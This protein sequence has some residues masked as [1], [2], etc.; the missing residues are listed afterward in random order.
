MKFRID[1]FLI[2]VAVVGLAVISLLRSDAI[3][4]TIFFSFTL[5]FVLLSV[6]LAVGRT[7]G[8]RVFWTGFGISSI[9]YLVVAHL[10]DADD[11]VPRHNGPEITTQLLRRGFNW[12]HSSTYFKDNNLMPKPGGVFS[13]QDQPLDFRAQVDAIQE[14]IDPDNWPSEPFPAKLS[15]VFGGQ[16][17][18]VDPFAFCERF[19]RIGHSAWALFFGW[20]GGHF[21]LTIDN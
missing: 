15:L 1:E 20:I 14:I 4:E 9:S 3:F 16:Q 2:V 17:L 10:P 21:A 12:L 8:A 5:L 7:G 6:L 13:V 19:M 18:A 11:M